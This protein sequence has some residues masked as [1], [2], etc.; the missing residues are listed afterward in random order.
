[1][2]Y[3]FSF[4]RLRVW[5][6]VMNL[7]KQVYQ[8]S[9]DFPKEELYGLTSQIRRAIVSVSSNLAEGGGRLSGKPDGSIKSI[10]GS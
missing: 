8:V 4:E 2:E 6:D 1:M 9:V 5:E 3:Q 10:V 7:T